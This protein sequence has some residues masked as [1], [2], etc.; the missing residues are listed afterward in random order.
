ME[1]FCYLGIRFFNLGM[2]EDSIN[3]FS[4]AIK[5]KTLSDLEDNYAGAEEE[6][7]GMDELDAPVETETKNN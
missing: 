1:Y 7:E 6:Q 2:F 3:Q 4:L 5:E